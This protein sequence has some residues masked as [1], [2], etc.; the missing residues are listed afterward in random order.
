MRNWQILFNIDTNKNNI[1][2]I[3]N[4]FKNKTPVSNHNEIYSNLLLNETLT[5]ENIEKIFKTNININYKTKLYLSMNK[6]ITID[7]IER[8]PDNFDIKTFERNSF[9][10]QNQIFDKNIK[11]KTKLFYYL[12]NKICYDLARYTTQQGNKPSLENPDI[13]Y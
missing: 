3:I 13:F 11:K 7:L 2:D 12:Y 9:K 4:Y 8:Y 5:S 10:Y 1:D 6:N